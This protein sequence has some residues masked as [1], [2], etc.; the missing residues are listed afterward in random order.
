METAKVVGV[1]CPE[2]VEAKD[3]MEKKKLHL[4]FALIRHPT[5]ACSPVDQHDEKYQTQHVQDGRETLQDL[6][7]ESSDPSAVVVVHLRRKM[8]D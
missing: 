3:A 8:N 5:C 4:V 2:K 6:A 1:D 7:N